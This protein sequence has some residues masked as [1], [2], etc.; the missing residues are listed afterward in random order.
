MSHSYFL[1]LIFA[2]VSEVVNKEAVKAGVCFFNCFLF[3]VS[4]VDFIGGA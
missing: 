4:T 1:F 2:L 3:L